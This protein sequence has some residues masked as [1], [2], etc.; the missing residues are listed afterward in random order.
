MIHPQKKK[1]FNNEKIN[2]ALMLDVLF[3]VST[4]FMV[5]TVLNYKCIVTF[6]I[7]L[8]LLHTSTCNIMTRKF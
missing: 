8:H 3:D 6:N 5:L 7:H 1:G 4:S 2:I